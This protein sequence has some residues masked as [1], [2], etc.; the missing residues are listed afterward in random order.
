[1]E[2]HKVPLKTCHYVLVPVVES[3]PWPLQMKNEYILRLTSFKDSFVN[4]LSVTKIFQDF[5]LAIL[6]GGWT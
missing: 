5:V 3:M 4:S 2:V 1:M 6:S